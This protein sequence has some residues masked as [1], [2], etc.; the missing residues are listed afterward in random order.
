MKIFPIHFPS[1][2]FQIS[3]TLPDI[4]LICHYYNYFLNVHHAFITVLE[5]TSLSILAL[6]MIVLVPEIQYFP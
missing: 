5:Y 1:L 4:N 3:P 6:K 2:P